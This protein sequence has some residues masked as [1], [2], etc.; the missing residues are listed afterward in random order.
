MNKGWTA[1][2]GWLVADCRS[3]HDYID[4]LPHSIVRSPSGKLVDITPR[5]PEAPPAVGIFPFL[6]HVG[7]AR[8][9]LD[10]LDNYLVAS[11]RLRGRT[12]IVTY[13]TE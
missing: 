7:E 9:F 12:A 11:L 1:V 2:H 4:L 8:E 3:S 6:S 10:F 13:F 5:P